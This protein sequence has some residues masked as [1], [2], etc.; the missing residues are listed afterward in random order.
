METIVKTKETQVIERFNNVRSDHST[1]IGN[2]EKM[3]RLFT[4]EMIRARLTQADVQY[5]HNLLALT[6]NDY[7]VLETAPFEI[8]VPPA[9]NSE[10]G[11][12]TA[13]IIEKY[14]Y[15]VWEKNQQILRCYEIMF[16]K[17][18]YGEAPI[19]VHR[20]KN[21]GHRILICDPRCSY[22]VIR[23]GTDDLWEMF[24]VEKRSNNQL[25]EWNKD[26]PDDYI[27]TDVLFYWNKT[28]YFVCDLTGKHIYDGKHGSDMVPATIARNPYYPNE[29]GGFSSMEWTAGLCT[30]LNQLMSDL[31]TI[32]HYNSAPIIIGEGTNVKR[33]E[34]V[35][36]PNAYNSISKGGRVYPLVIGEPAMLSN[37][38]ARVSGHYQEA[39]GLPGILH[40]KTEDTV[41][42]E[43]AI[44]G[45]SAGAEIRIQLRRNIVSPSIE[46]V[47]KI[48]LRSTE[49]A[50]SKS[51]PFTTS[52]ASRTVHQL[53]PKKIA[54]N[55]SNTIQFPIGLLDYASKVVTVLQLV[56]SKIMSR[57]H[58]R[59]LLQIRSP[60][61]EEEQIKKETLADLDFQMKLKGI[62]T[63]G[64]TPGSQEGAYNPSA[65]GGRPHGKYVPP[66][67][68]ENE[69]RNRER[70]EHGATSEKKPFGRPRRELPSP[71][72]TGRLILAEVV[73][74]LASVNRIRG[75]IFIYGTIVQKGW[76]DGTIDLMLTDMIDKQ[77][78]LNGLPI[79]K[80]RFDFKRIPPSGKPPG[81]FMVIPKRTEEPTSEAEEMTTTEE[82]NG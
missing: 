66:E 52:K 65:T 45:L 15:S 42:S 33:N 40:G 4:G 76:T 47:N 58:A 56:N 51:I 55:Y 19:I 46:Q 8:Q 50:N 68:A 25:R 11:I 79:W 41:V 21:S 30:Y 10:D 13:D 62:A 3:Y 20:H 36:G 37:H 48:I 1:R 32:V 28:D 24:Y 43:K 82:P 74:A 73:R 61:D 17:N 6:I 49:M 67:Q 12:A 64:Q 75:R 18:L 5:I 57:N 14:L 27:K 7:A 54:G 38:I 60:R 78:I 34:W 9:D 63:Q 71:Q 31:A 53:D 44:K 70:F 81:M 22:P 26:F 59:D 80:G 23:E 2:F 29:I 39:S 35:T 72:E 77:T 16:L 69:A